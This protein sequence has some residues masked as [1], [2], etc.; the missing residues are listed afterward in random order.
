MPPIPRAPLR[1]AAVQAEP[2]PGDVAGNAAVAARLAG[3]AAGEGAR[4][5]VLPELF[6]PGYH[7][8]ALRADPVGTHL[9]ADETGRISDIRLDRLRAVARDQKVVIV[10]SAAVRHGDGRRTISAL[11][12]DRRGGVLSAYDKQH[13]WRDEPDLFS[14][15][16]EGAT[17]AVDGWWLG[18][19]ICYDMSFPE[20]G[21]AAADDGAHGYLCP[22]GYLE[23]SQHRRDLQGA[24]RALDNT[25]YV[26][27]ANQVGGPSPWR[28]NGGSAIYEPEG[29]PLRRAPDFGEHVIIADF[30]PTELGRIR[31]AHRMLTDRR[32]D[33]GGARRL[34]RG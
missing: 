5:V 10:L 31:A 28:F 11:V 25:M 27:F 22:I 8:P 19:G 4:L 18:L 15:G 34:C 20:H 13:L 29:R 12:V 33:L 24:A 30:D 21:R 16:T 3:R 7:P 9:A 26:V 1:V 6:L 23:G 2:N 32:A 17:L 14:A